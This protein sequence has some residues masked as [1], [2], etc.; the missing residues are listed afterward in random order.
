MNKKLKI[1]R[2]DVWLVDLD[3][4]KGHEQ[5]KTRPC[6]V[7]SPDSFNNGPGKLAMIVP[8][9][10]IYRPLSWFVPIEPP[11]GGVAKRSY[12]MCNQLRVVAHE[13]FTNTFLVQ[14]SPKRLIIL[15]F[16]CGFC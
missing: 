11:N 4:V 13:R 8:L 10:S 12:I 14:L 5:A 15:S 2:G 6:V 7:V 9:T 16:G 3:P 1:V